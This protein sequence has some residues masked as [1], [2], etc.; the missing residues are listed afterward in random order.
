MLEQLLL[1]YL[2]YSPI[3]R[4]KYRLVEKFGRGQ[5]VARGFS[6]KPG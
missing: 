6:D 3:R 5:A 1:A 2:R 4:G